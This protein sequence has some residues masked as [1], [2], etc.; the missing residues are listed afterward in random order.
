[1]HVSSTVV[2]FIYY[3]QIGYVIFQKKKKKLNSNFNL[4]CV[5]LKKKIIEKA[6]ASATT[7]RRYYRLRQ[8]G[9]G[10]R[11]Q[12]QRNFYSTF[13]MEKLRKS[14]YLFNKR[15]TL[16]INSSNV[17]KKQEIKQKSKRKV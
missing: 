14:K 9:R 16:T 11:Q 3:Y 13:S 2:R 15:L 6:A 7:V 10:P 4:N 8:P 1:M 5:D 12:Q 17:K